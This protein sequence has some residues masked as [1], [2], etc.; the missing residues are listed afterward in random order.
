MEFKRLEQLVKDNNNILLIG[1][2][3]PDG[4]TIGALVAFSRY[5]KS[6]KIQHETI[7][8]DLLPEVFSFI[9]QKTKIVSD[10]LLEDCDLIILLD[11]GDLKRT[12]F[13]G[14]LVE[15]KDKKIKIANIDHHPRND[16]WKLTKYNFANPALSSSCQI[17]FN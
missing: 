16:I 17:L 14:R 2:I 9:S 3:K 10:F 5:L 12:G 7:L 15:A 6:I 8:K 13:V 4:D 11:C 1:H